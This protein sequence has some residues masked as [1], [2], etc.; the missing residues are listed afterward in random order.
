MGL[1]KDDCRVRVARYKRYK[2]GYMDMGED[3]M[4]DE[5]AHRDDC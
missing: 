1:T 4:S 2:K 5:G 3:L